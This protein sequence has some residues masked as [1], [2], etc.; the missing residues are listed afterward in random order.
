MCIYR[1]ENNNNNTT[2]TTTTTNNNNNI[3]K[4]H[5]INIYNETKQR[6]LQQRRL[7]Q[8]SLITAICSLLRFGQKN[9]ENASGYI[10]EHRYGTSIFAK[11]NLMVGSSI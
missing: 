9:A 3:K 6:R 10:A 5:K 2:T 4:T 7:Q 1:E 8:R 11:H